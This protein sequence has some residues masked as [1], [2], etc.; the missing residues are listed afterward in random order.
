MAEDWVMV[1]S[2]AHEY[3][4]SLFKILLE[5][6]YGFPVVLMDRRDSAYMIGEVELYVKPEDAILARHFISKQVDDE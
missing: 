2:S 4:P 1:F 5:E 3:K 6:E